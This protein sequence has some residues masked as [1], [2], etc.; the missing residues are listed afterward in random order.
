MSDCVWRNLRHWPKGVG[1]G[2]AEVAFGEG[3]QLLRELIAWAG[4]HLGAG[5]RAVRRTR[6]SQSCSAAPLL[7]HALRWCLS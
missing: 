5:F 3:E 4:R 1:A 6:R 2:Y 7:A